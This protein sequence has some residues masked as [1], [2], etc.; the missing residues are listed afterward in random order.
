[1]HEQLGVDDRRSSP[2]YP[3]SNGLVEAHNKILKRFVIVSSI[4]SFLLND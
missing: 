4:C 3:Q 1:M 2:Y